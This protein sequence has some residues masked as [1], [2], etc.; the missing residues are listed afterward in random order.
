MLHA[1]RGRVGDERFF[2]L[3]Q[4]WTALHRHAT[5]TTAQ[6]VELAEQHAGTDLSQF[7]TAW[8]HR[9]TLPRISG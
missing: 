3:L 4:D 6:F 5:V 9:P 7:F 2:A 8:L 1:L